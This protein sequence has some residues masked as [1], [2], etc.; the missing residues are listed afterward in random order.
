[1]DWATLDLGHPW[2]QHLWGG[3]SSRAPP[4]LAPARDPQGTALHLHPQGLRIQEQGPLGDPETR[5]SVPTFP[6]QR[7]PCTPHLLWGRD[8]CGLNPEQEQGPSLSLFTPHTPLHPSPAEW[9]LVLSP[10]GLE[11]QGGCSQTRTPRSPPHPQ[12][13]IN[14]ILARFPRWPLGARG[15]L[16]SHFLKRRSV[17]ME[18][19]PPTLS[20]G[21]AQQSVPCSWVGSGTGGLAPGPPPPH[22]AQA[23]LRDPPKPGAGSICCL[24]PPGGAAPQGASGNKGDI[25]PVW[26][27]QQPTRPGEDRATPGLIHEGS[28]HPRGP[29]GATSLCAP[30][31]GGRWAS[32]LR[33][34]SPS[35]RVPGSLTGPGWPGRGQVGP[36]AV[37][38]DA[39]SQSPRT[40]TLAATLRPALTCASVTVAAR[41]CPSRSRARVGAP[42]M[43]ALAL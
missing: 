42:A 25:V 26:W 13:H 30:R 6:G 36:P 20:R 12:T 28:R 37:L 8:P 39:P 38:L 40:P 32:R 33:R 5:T 23:C 14:A 2:R 4:K 1:M 9:D 18:L 15:A 17:I 35:V 27:Q 31:R 34:R 21:S 22:P 29:R 43:A 19:I 11:A 10:S 24:D 3:A 16:G 41:S 7:L